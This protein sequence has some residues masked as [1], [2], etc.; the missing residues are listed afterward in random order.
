MQECNAKTN[1]PNI[2]IKLAMKWKLFTLNLKHITIK[3]KMETNFDCAKSNPQKE[4]N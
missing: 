3:L 4:K 1:G 2:P